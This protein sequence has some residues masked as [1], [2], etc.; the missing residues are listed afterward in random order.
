MTPDALIKALE[1]YLYESFPAEQLRS[2]GWRD[3]RKFDYRR[4]DDPVVMGCRVLV[5]VFGVASVEERC[6]AFACVAAFVTEQRQGTYPDPRV[7]RSGVKLM[8]A[9]SLDEAA[10]CEWFR[11]NCG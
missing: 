8:E 3:F 7:F 9:A 2:L 6:S 1:P 11:N 10:I 4:I 5:S